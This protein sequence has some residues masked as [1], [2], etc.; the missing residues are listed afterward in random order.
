MIKNAKLSSYDFCMNLNIWGDF[1][2][3]ISVPLRQSYT[4]YRDVIESRQIRR[5]FKLMILIA[6]VLLCLTVSDHGRTLY[7]KFRQNR[8]KQDSSMLEI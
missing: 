8:F 6:D 7:L 2:S 5:M 3:C 4:V 1:Q